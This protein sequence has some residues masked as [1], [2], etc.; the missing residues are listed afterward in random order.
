MLV[1]IPLG[2]CKELCISSFGSYCYVSVQ[3]VELG[4]RFIAVLDFL[5][6]SSSHIYILHEMGSIFFN[7]ILPVVVVVGHVDCI[8]EGVLKRELL[9]D[10]D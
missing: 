6:C 10:V 4:D 5:N 9:E 3:R 2:I 1:P 8:L 7:E